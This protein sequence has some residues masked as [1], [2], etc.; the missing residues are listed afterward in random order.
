MRHLF[1]NGEPDGKGMYFDH[2]GL[3]CAT[4]FPDRDN[5]LVRECGC[6]ASDLILALE[7]A[8]R[9]VQVRND[10]GEWVSVPLNDV[11]KGA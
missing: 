11:N 9:W 6:P 1:F 2:S 3:S 7:D 5:P 4:Y 8:L 10:A